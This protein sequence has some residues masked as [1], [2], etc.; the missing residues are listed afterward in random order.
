MLASLI[1]NSIR[2]RRSVIVLLV[3]LL[4]AGAYA[5]QT[6][7]IDALPDVSTIQVSVM[8]NASGMTPTEIERTVRPSKS[9]LNRDRFWVATAVIVATPF[10]TPDAG[11]SRRPRSSS[12]ATG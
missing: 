5:A 12:T 1:R 3:V 2:Y 9:K 8:T 11:S 4:G 10:S 6:L 7:P